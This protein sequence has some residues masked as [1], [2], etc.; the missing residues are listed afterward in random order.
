MRVILMRHGKP[1]LPPQKPV[2]SLEFK[3]WI[4]SYNSAEL[5]EASKPKLTSIEIAQ[6]CNA[7]LCSSLN[8]SLKSASILGINEVDLV[9]HELREMEIPWGKSFGF[10]VN[11]EYWA[12]IFRILWFLGYSKNSESFEE[13]KLR[14]INAA[15]LLESTAKE[16]DSVLF[17]GHGMLNRYIAKHLIEKGWLVS[18]KAGSNYW[19]FSVFERFT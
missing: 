16:K 6:S 4:D 5:C 13:A 11:P 14:A 17:V 10:R 9:E 7:V 12:I 15:S 2:T 8:R 1:L 19:E 3:H 18:K